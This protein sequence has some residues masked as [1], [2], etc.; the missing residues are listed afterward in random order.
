MWIS[1]HVETNLGSRV[2][3]VQQVDTPLELGCVWGWITPLDVVLALSVVW[4]L[5]GVGSLRL[6]L[7]SKIQRGLVVWQYRQGGCGMLWPG[8]P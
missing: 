6:F 3:Y 7:G 4:L 1:F 5:L 8:H 2:E